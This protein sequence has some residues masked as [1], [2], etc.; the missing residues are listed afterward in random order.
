VNRSPEPFAAYVPQRLFLGGPAISPDGLE[1]AAITNDGGQFNLWVWP[2]GDGEPR[3]LTSFTDQAVR[4]VAWSPDGTA[5][6]FMAD[7]DGDEQ[8]QVFVL[9]RDGGEPRR[10]SRTDGRQH[11]LGASPFS[12]DGSRLAYA[13][14]DRDESVQDL[15]VHD[16]GTGEVMRI[17]SVVGENLEA[18]AFSPDGRWLLGA[19]GRS[20]T[21]VDA[22]LVDLDD[23]ACPLRNVTAHDGEVQHLPARWLPD[24]SAFFLL[25]NAGAEFRA[26]A[27]CSL[28]GDVSVLEAPA[29]DV[30]GVLTSRDGQVRLWMVNEAG[31]T[32]VQGRRGDPNGVGDGT[33]FQVP[34]PNGV[35]NQATLSRDGRTIAGLFASGARPAELVTIDVDTGAMTELTDSRPP[36]LASVERGSEPGVERGSEPGVERGSEPGERGSEPELVHFPTHDGRQI[37]GWLYRPAVGDGPRPVV[38]SIHGGP[39]TQER[40]VYAYAGLYQFLLSRGIGI[41]APNVRG[42]TGYGTSYQTLIHR[43]WG[44][45]ELGDFEHAVAF[46]HGLDWVD[47]D[48]IGVFGGSFGGF[49]ALSCVSRLPDLFA[50]GVSIVG[51]SNLVTL[52]RSVPPTWRALMANWV[53]D[54]DDDHDFLMSRS[55]V[56]YA[57]QIVAP[58]MVVQGANDPRV[59][60]AESDQIVEALRARGVEVRYDVYEDEG[61]GFTRRHNEIQALGDVAEFLVTQLTTAGTDA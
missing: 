32:V 19:I 18:V 23:P 25:T 51:P 22:C 10:I 11:W 36:A 43:D 4:Q 28:D 14:N 20:N 26:L 37:P 50:A 46:L 29:W 9:D 17:E 21:D 7:R 52:A 55:P 24:S 27:T 47:P 8:F 42:S 2:L 59:A 31:V 13:G 58:L 49:A 34:L 38:L 57:D 48:R 45:A 12:L 44:G 33:A 39:E 6:A 16:L 61:H 60:K 1:V 54:P 53:G 3:Q 30:D 56:T 40:P 5:L 35:L 15:V 41:L